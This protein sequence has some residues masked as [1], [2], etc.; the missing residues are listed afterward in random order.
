MRKKIII[1]TLSVFIITLFPV[2]TISAEGV[3]ELAVVDSKDQGYVIFSIFENGIIRTQAAEEGLSNEYFYNEEII[4]YNIYESN[5]YLATS[6]SI[7]VIPVTENPLKSSDDT[8]IWEASSDVDIVSLYAVRGNENSEVYVVFALTNK[9]VIS[10]NYDVS[11]IATTPISIDI[12]ATGAQE[13]ITTKPC[14]NREAVVFGGNE[15][16]YVFKEGDS[17]NVVWNHQFDSNIKQI[18]IY[19]EL[20][21]IRT[22]NKIN[23]YNLNNIIENRENV[24][25]YTSGHK[26]SSPF[27]IYEEKIYYEYQVGNEWNIIE[28]EIDSWTEIDHKEALSGSMENLGFCAKDNV[29]YAVTEGPSI[30]A[31]NLSPYTQKWETPFTAYTPTTGPTIGVKEGVKRIFVGL[32]SDDT[33]KASVWSISENGVQLEEVISGEEPEPQPTPPNDKNGI[34]PIWYL[35]LAVILIAAAAVYIRYRDRRGKEKDGDDFEDLED[36]F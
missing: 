18:E 29:L 24:T 32:L 7:H 16:V 11:M 34:N 27:I 19:K 2:C 8:K 13:P 20:L 6:K 1:L 12:I 4:D 33:S 10:Y 22:E 9:T 36:L 5:F 28:L 25:E 3:K 31:F 21:L 35:V 26:P 23:I 17:D 15:F 30:H 14:Y